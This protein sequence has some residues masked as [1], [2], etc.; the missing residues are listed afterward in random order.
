MWVNI[1]FLLV[2]SYIIFSILI[3]NLLIYEFF[4]LSPFI[5][6]LLVFNY[7]LQ[8]KFMVFFLF[9]SNSFDILNP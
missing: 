4:F 1:F 2:L 8:P 6:V 9:S 5:E 7:I 3:F